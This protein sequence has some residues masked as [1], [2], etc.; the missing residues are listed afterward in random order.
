MIFWTVVILG[1]YLV[2]VLAIGFHSGRGA[3]KDAEAFFVAGRKLN[4]LQESMAVFTTTCSAGAIVGTTGLFY[5]DGADMVG[6]IVAFAFVMPL[7]YWYVGARLRRLGRERGYQTQAAFLGD[8]YQSH[9]LRWGAALA[10]ALFSVPYFMV[11]PV[12]LGILLKEATGF[13]YWAGALL[14]LVVAMLYTVKGGLRAVADT[15]IFHGVLLLVFFLAALVVLVLH[16]GGFINILD[17]TKAAVATSGHGMAM[18]YVWMLYSGLITFCWPDRAFRMF[19]VRD[20]NNMRKG[21]M[22]SAA[23]MA[24]AAVSFLIIGLSVNKILPG[25]KNTDTTLMSAL[26]LVAVWLVPWLVMN[27]WGSGMATFTAGMLSTANIFIKDIFEP[28]YARRRDLL[29][30]RK[31]DRLLVLA[32]RL[33]MLF[34]GL[35]T[36]LVCFYPP[37]FIWNLINVTLGLF[38]QFSPILL[39][40][41]AWRGVTRLGAQAAWTTGVV[42]QFFWTFLSKPPSGTMAGF[43]ALAVNTVVLITVSLVVPEN[44]QLKQEREDMRVVANGMDEEAARATVTHADPQCR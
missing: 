37:P 26:S 31:R 11:G 20:D 4:W 40:G 34:L 25:I 44:K 39:L 19:A 6:Y 35:A 42:C 1:S 13:P 28:W 15:D 41:L 8:F 30:G 43:D 23:M 10:G 24:F 22:L 36:V 29:P 14:F 27:T 38:L 18:F 9:Y 5:R 17:S 3:G 21:V 32:A 33:F 16:G 12:A 2:I 7:T